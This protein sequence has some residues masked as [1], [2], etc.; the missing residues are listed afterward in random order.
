M[1]YG[2]WERTVPEVLTSDP[3]WSMRSCR[4]AFYLTAVAWDDVRRVG[5]DRHTAGMA[6][7]MYRAVGSVGANIMEGYSKQ[8]GRDQARYYEYALGS[9]RESMLWY[10]AARHVLDAAVLEQRL[11]LL[12][13]IRRLL[14][15]T[16]A[17]Q[18]KQARQA[19]GSRRRI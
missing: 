8:S 12:S 5:R 15:V 9:A 3:A 19:N 2:D 17:R 10:Y 4:L 18:R 11:Q 1:E 14:L 6:S 16:I 7:Q 13:E